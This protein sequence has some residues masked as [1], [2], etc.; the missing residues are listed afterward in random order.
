MDVRILIDVQYPLEGGEANSNFLLISYTLS[1]FIDESF[2]IVGTFD[3][4][5]IRSFSS[6]RPSAHKVIRL[7]IPDHFFQ[8]VSSCLQQMLM[9][10]H[11]GPHIIRVGLEAGA[12]GWVGAALIM[13]SSLV[14]QRLNSGEDSETGQ[15]PSKQ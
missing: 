14:A 7:Y 2:I 12:K 9:V 8:N 15:S 10:I 4:M 6:P 13:G 11:D 5:K 1:V 3:N